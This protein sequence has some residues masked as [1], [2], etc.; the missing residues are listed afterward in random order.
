MLD[1]EEK[2]QYLL[3]TFKMEKETK[4]P[5]FTLY[6]F[7]AHSSKAPIYRIT[8]DTILKKLTYS[9][10]TS[11]LSQLPFQKPYTVNTVALVFGQPYIEFGHLSHWSQMQSQTGEVGVQG[12]ER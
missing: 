11:L 4:I 5:A 2:G 8:L 12:T 7:S 10:T 9:G 6:L 3:A 1:R